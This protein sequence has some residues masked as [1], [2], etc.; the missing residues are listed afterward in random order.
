MNKDRYR[1]WRMAI[2]AAVGILVG[3][4]VAAEVNVIIPLIGIGAAMALSYLLRKRVKDV[5]EDERSNLIAEKAARLAFGITMP[6]VVIAALIM[7]M[8][9]ARFSPDWKLAGTVLAY[10]AC[11]QM[12]IFS[13]THLYQDRKH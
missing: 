3:W 11:A 4:S 8:W 13:I 10:A 5:I 12:V 7:I 9:G 6:L 2:T 1:K